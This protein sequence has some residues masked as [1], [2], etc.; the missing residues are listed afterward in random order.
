MRKLARPPRKLESSAPLAWWDHA[1]IDSGVK[2]GSVVVG[3]LA[4][5][6]HRADESFVRRPPER[7]VFIS[8][9]DRNRALHGD[10]VA[11][12]L[13]PESR[14]RRLVKTPNPNTPA[15]S[16][17]P[18]N[19]GAPNLWL[20]TVPADFLASAAPVA[21]A[22]PASAV[23]RHAALETDGRQPA[24]VVVAVLTASDAG[25]MSA[26]RMENRALTG[27]LFVSKG[28]PGERM[29][30]DLTRAC[31]RP[32]D[33]RLPVLSIPRGEL[34]HD[35]VQDPFGP[36]SKKIYEAKLLDWPAGAEEPNGQF[37][38]LVGEEGDI[39]SET[40][41]LLITHDVDHGEFPAPAVACLQRFLPPPQADTNPDTWWS[42]PAEE[43]EARRDLRGTLIY[44]VDPLTAK[45][46][47]DAMH[48]AVLADGTF[49]VGVHIADVSF[50][51]EP[52]SALDLEAARRC[53]SVYLV[54]RVI[55]MLPALLSE[56]LCSL[57]PDVDR[58]AFSCIWRMSADGA[59]VPGHRPWYGRTIIKSCAK[60]D[61]GL[62]QRLIDEGEAATWAGPKGGRFAKR[63][64]VESLRTLHKVAMARRAM[65]FDPKSGGAL[66]MAA[67]KMS[68]D[69]D[70]HG[71]PRGVAPYRLHETNSMVEEYMLLANFL[72]AQRLIEGAKGNAFLRCHPN[73]DAR[74]MQA[75][76][77]T[78]ERGAGVK[79]FPS[80]SISAGELHHAM[81]RLASGAL[82]AQL[83]GA[84]SVRG[85]LMVLASEMIKKPMKPA[86]YFVSQDEPQAQ[87]RHWALNI[88]YYTHFTSPIRASMHSPCPRNWHARRSNDAQTTR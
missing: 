18:P 52:S 42:I 73:P 61:Y 3:V 29:H 62:A 23:P 50:F 9:A 4:V 77:A 46:L 27:T 31:F 1:R 75:V 10:V 24:G 19:N 86:R 40:Q 47:D 88:P 26:A 76:A 78:L 80:G 68:F 48:V 28:K 71:N 83:M 11:V 33:A 13:L 37:V 69:L 21:A 44:T 79:L 38:R 49:E 41:A 14:W 30:S 17:A 2:D 58:L 36:A 51:V 56:Q 35:F 67:V 70:E 87:W 55:P 8:A 43:L 16:H 72:V 59:L 85:D 7:D 82:P 12:Q 32:K 6:P 20:P 15:L 39:A 84:E 25:K 57:N 60:L 66:A 22:T 65:R 74:Q 64:V 45:D 53:T 81:S 34:P 63:D 54:Q 5:S